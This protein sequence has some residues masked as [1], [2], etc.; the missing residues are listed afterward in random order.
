MSVSGQR[1]DR[2]TRAYVE[3]PYE[4][5]NGRLEAVLPEEGPC[6][7]QGG[8][9]CRVSFHHRRERK[10][11]I[12]WGWVAVAHCL[13][14]GGGFTLY[15]PGHVPYGREPMAARGPDGHPV[16]A[17]DER[18]AS[19]YFDAARDAAR[20]ERW[21]RSDAP[22]PPGAVASTQ[23]RRLERAAGLLGLVADVPPDL[24]TAAGVTDLGPGRLLDASHALE[25]SRSLREW[26]ARVSELLGRLRA[27]AG[28]GW[29]DRIRLLGRG[30][31]LWGRCYRVQPTTLRLREVTFPWE[32]GAGTTAFSRSPNR[33]GAFYEI[34]PPVPP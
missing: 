14:H 7:G 27:M 31:G 29:L 22:D 34:G 26:G 28:R 15:P 4:E 20:G 17:G 1:R 11:G 24:E 30:A 21:P 3:A 6:R 10:T 13:E 25:R 32:R 19:T 2:A 16:A 33:R 5:R 18:D 12:P 8:C 9:T 23:R